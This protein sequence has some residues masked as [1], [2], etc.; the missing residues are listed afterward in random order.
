DL[1]P[2]VAVI[3]LACAAIPLARAHPAPTWPDML[4]AAYRAPAAADAS[5]VW[6]DEQHAAGLDAPNPAWS[7][8]RTIPLT[9]CI[10][11]GLAVVLTARAEH[12]SLV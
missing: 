7:A 11:L 1:A 8:L 9:G 4:P 6:A 10:V 2:F 12:S 3:V 5:A